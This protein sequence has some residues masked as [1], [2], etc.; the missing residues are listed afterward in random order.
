MDGSFGELK[1]R[2]W[3]FIVFIVGMVILLGIMLFA[4]EEELD[5]VD[6]LEDLVVNQKVSL[7][8][9][10]VGEK[11]IYEDERILELDNGIV[12]VC[13]NCRECLDKEVLIKG[14]VSE[15]NGEK[16]VRVFRLSVLG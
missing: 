7:A 8:G 10:V 13:S 12:A 3:A 9:K 6:E 5:S 1:M 16:Q 14:V 4:G 2:K 15:Y 11:I